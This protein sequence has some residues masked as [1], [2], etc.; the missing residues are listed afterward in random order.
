MSHMLTTKTDFFRATLAYLGMDILSVSLPMVN[1]ISDFHL[2]LLLFQRS[3]TNQ[4][5]FQDRACLKS[6]QEPIHLAHARIFIP[7]SSRLTKTKTSLLIAPRLRNRRRNG[8][9]K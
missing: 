9:R 7:R 3:E 2:A 6:I 1:T 5:P 8:S 4:T